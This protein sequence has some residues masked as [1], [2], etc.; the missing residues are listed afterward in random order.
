M[1][2][3]TSRRSFMKAAALLTGSAVLSP[4]R[5]LG[6]AGSRLRRPNIVFILADDMGWV[7]SSTYGSEYY[8]TPNLD[9][10]AK[11]GMLFTDAY[12]ASPVC[13]PTRA[14]LLT[15][16]YPARLGITSPVCHLP[17]FDKDHPR[18][19]KGAAANR[20]MVTPNSRRFLE[21]EEYTVA[22]AFRD[23]GYKTGIVGKWHLGNVA[24]HLPGRQGFEEDMGSPN[25]APP[26]YFSPYKLTNF[27][28]GPKGEYVTDRVTDESLKFIDENKDKEFMLCVW[29]FAV[30]APF[31]AKAEMVKYYSKKEDPRDKQKCAV[32]AAMIH[33]LDESVGRILDKIDELKLGED[34][35]IIFMSDNGGNMF[36]SV[37]GE[38]ATN[39]APLRGGKGNCYEGGTRCPCIFVWP[40]VVEEGSKSDTVIS[41]VDFYPTMLEMAGI[42]K[43]KSQVFDGVNIV[44]VL[45]GQKKL[46]REAIFCDFPTYTPHTQNLPS[47]YVRSG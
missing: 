14:S 3:S 31:Q 37:K 12:A 9:R 11:R 32:M 24:E 4:L 46:G 1:T 8:E 21:P 22:E 7:D 27:P 44:P 28:D 20:K 16:K 5:C 29:H 6:M 13:S 15:G 18:I 41:A 47:V 19:N 25:P 10:L 38:P 23:A 36:N 35:I 45:K 40:G 30:H 34:T 26:S 33:S 17:P 2:Q 43:R 39:N 42:E